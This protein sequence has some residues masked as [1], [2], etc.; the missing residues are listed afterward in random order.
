MAVSSDARQKE[1]AGRGLYFFFG[2]LNQRGVTNGLS[3]LVKDESRT[4]R[5]P[6][7]V[8]AELYRCSQILRKAAPDLDAALMGLKSP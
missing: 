5:A 4:F 8:Q 1:A 6:A 2:R 7:D 3:K